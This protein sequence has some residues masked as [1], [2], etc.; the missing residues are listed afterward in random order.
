METK[1]FGAFLR[2]EEELETKKKHHHWFCLAIGCGENSSQHW[3]NWRRRG[4]P[5]RLTPKAAKVL[6]V[7]LDW[8]LTGHGE[9]RGNVIE[10]TT[11]PDTLVINGV[12]YVKLGEQL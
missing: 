4:F 3:T 10:I 5:A 1:G 2:I 7:S 12:T 6:G 9:K 11:M 8:L